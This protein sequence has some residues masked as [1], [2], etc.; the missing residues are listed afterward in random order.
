MFIKVLSVFWVLVITRGLMWC[1]EKCICQEENVKFFCRDVSERDFFKYSD[2]TREIELKNS[3]VGL[4][5]ITETFKKLERVSFVESTVLDCN[6]LY[7]VRVIGVCSD[8]SNSDVDGLKSKGV[9]SK[10]VQK[11]VKKRTFDITVAVLIVGGIIFSVVGIVL[12]RQRLVKRYLRIRKERMAYMVRLGGFDFD[13]D[14]E[15]REN[16]KHTEEAARVENKG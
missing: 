1:H 6:S 7:F 2:L 15:D 5:W 14:E 3:M 12:V 13:Q 9:T 4:H 11:W 16:R 10:S 8:R